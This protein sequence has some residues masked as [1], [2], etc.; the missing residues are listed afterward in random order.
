MANENYVGD[1]KWIP[2]GDSEKEAQKLVWST[3][4]I[5]DLMVALD[6]GYRPQVSMPFYE[7][8]QFLRRGNIVFDYTD[9]ELK[10]IT[11]CANDIVYF[12]EKYAVV[13]TDNGIQ[14]VKLR[15][16]QKDL[17]RDFQHNRFN[18][19]LASRQMGKCFFYN[20]KIDIQDPQGS[21]RTMSI[22]DLYYN[23]LKKKRSLKLTE[24][25]KWKLWNI[26]AYIDKP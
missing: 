13:M 21:I 3:K 24:L 18:I 14:K 10:E 12:A 19:V 6:K 22:G 15:E 1:N 8:K 23:M 7:G 16:Y 17:L 2:A 5:N 26:Y 9:E 11:K 20:T 25:L 4:I